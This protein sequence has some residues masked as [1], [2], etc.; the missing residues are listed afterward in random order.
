MEMALRVALA[1]THSE[2]FLTWKSMF[3]G[4]GFFVDGRIFAAWFG[5]ELALK[6]PDDA[7]A[8]LIADGGTATRETGKYVETPAHY[9]DEP[10][11]LEPWVTR[12]IDYVMSAKA[13]KR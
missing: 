6:L 4:V 7:I 12:S 10:A 2:R 5:S 1:N 3:G 8:E 11:L 9:L 13:K